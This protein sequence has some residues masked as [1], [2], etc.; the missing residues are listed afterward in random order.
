MAL[1]SSAIMPTEMLMAIIRKSAPD[2]LW[3]NRTLLALEAADD[4][5]VDL[6]ADD[7]IER[8]FA[9]EHR[10]DKVREYLSTVPGWPDD[11]MSAEK[12]VGFCFVQAISI[13]RN[14]AAGQTRIKPKSRC[15]RLR[16]IG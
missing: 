14:S 10:S 12:M 5:R 1:P 15:N 9:A 6:L 11:R 7:L 2:D 4:A 16:S 3:R 13:L 8:F